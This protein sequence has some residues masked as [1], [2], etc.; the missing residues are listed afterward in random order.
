MAKGTF[1]AISNTATWLKELAMHALM[2]SV[3]SL[4]QV[5][6][7]VQTHLCTRML[8]HPHKRASVQVADAMQYLH[9]RQPMLIHRDIKPE[10]G[11]SHT[12]AYSSS[13]D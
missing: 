3:L 12:L 2:F 8:V 5:H 1:A 13:A 6:A 10:V 4:A 7:Y 11:R 9:S